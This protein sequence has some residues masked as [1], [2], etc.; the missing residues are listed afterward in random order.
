[1]AA[2]PES[3]IAARERDKTDQQAGCKWHGP[4]LSRLR[5]TEY[6]PRTLEI[7]CHSTSD[8]S[9][10]INDGTRDRASR[11]HHSPGVSCM[12]VIVI[13]N[14]VAG[15]TVARAIR[16]SD[17]GVELDIFT[18]EAIP[19]YPRPKL[20]DLLEGKAAESELAFYPLEWY[21][22]HK[23]GL[24]LDHRAEKIDREGRK[25]FVRGRWER[26]D[27]LVLATGSHAFVPPLPGLPKDNVFTLR[28]LADAKRI[29]QS[30]ARSAR[31]VVIG[32]GLLGLETSMAVCTAFP[33][34]GITILE[35]GEHLLGR[36]LDHEGGDILQSWIESTGAKVLVRAETKEIIGSGCE[37]EG[38]LLKD[39]RRIDADMV[40]ISAGTRPNTELAAAA[41]LKV[42]RGVAVDASLRTSDEDIF[43]LGDVAEFEGQL[44]AM[45]PPALDE[46]KV[47]AKKILGQ[48][49]PDYAGTVPSNTLKVAGFDLTSI[50]MAR[51]LHGPSGPGVEEIK[52]IT[53]DRKV[54]KKFVLRDGR[55]IGAILLGTRKEAVKVSRLIKDGTP[56]GS[57]RDRLSDPSYTF[58]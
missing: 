13:G 1:M 18:D 53:P 37:A 8:S 25:I 17:P 49:G 11:K 38:V 46:A 23:I 7:T 57:I 39:G 6:E 14:N 31:A 16:D 32:G 40:I 10:K 44:W 21:A 27:R 4:A 51:H 48:A 15:T 45:I 43:A 3:E 20:I 30:A 9:H 22:D 28:T 24:H 36:Q 52:A 34:L 42:G 5:T 41:G 19:Y 35:N 29:R 50:G 54:Y 2:D 47:A 55:M 12:R 58:D 33:E 26:Y 56:V